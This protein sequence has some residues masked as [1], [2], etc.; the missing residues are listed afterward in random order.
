MASKA[1][2]T[3]AILDEEGKPFFNADYRFVP[4]KDETIREG[5]DGTIV[6]Y[7]EMLYRCLDAVDRLRS[8]GIRV[9]LI[10][11]PTLNVVDETMMEKLGDSPF[12]LVVESQNI[13]SG[14]GAR[15]GTW[16]LERGFKA[17]YAHMGVFREGHG[18]LEEQIPYQRLGN[19]DIREKIM[20]MR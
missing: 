18:G 9:A 11:K 6:S 16:L 2:A 5:Q 4:G 3:L 12:V 14:L 20:S 17:R 7:G 8:E 1:S 19:E 15:F 10:N 13:K